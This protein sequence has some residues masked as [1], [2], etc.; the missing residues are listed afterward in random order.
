MP[1]A[2][3]GSWHSALAGAALCALLGILLFLLGGWP[4]ALGY[5]LL[6][7]FRKSPPPNDIA[8]IYM[9]DDSFKDLRQTS[10][11]NWDRNLHA[12]LLDRLTADGC[13]LVV[14]DIVFSE[15]GTPQANSNFVRAIKNNGKVVLA[16]AINDPGRAQIAVKQSFMPL[17]EFEDAAAGVGFAAVDFAGPGRV[18]RAYYAGDEYRPGLPRV[19]ARVAGISPVR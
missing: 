14:F 5:D 2:F 10:L 1:K 17:P 3:S 7:F 15:P 18:A 9:D 6:F 11:P 12:T 16:A 4:V 8:T 19:A 13:K